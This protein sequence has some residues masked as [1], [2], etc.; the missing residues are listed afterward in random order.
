MNNKELRTFELKTFNGTPF[1]VLIKNLPDINEKINN[2]NIEIFKK[3]G[4]FNSAENRHTCVLCNNK[5]SIDDSISSQGNKLICIPCTYKYFEGDYS[6]VF[7]WNKR[8]D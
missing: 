8:G 1:D 7:I 6:V 4:T 3:Q 2:D 5:T